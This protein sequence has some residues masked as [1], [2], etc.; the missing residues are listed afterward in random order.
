MIRTQIQLTEEQSRRVKEIAAQENI[1]MAEVIR[2]AV[3]AWLVTH[4]EMGIEEKRER[5]LAVVKEMRGE[6]HS[7]HSDISVNHDAYVTEAFGDYEPR[8]DL[9]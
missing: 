9:P 2:R 7:G 5:A 3:D 1:S 4:G 6:F 8:D